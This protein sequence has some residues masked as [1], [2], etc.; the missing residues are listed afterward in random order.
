MIVSEDM[1]IDAVDD[2][3]V[4][5]SVIKRSEVLRTTPIFVSRT[6]SYSITATNSS[7]NNSRR[8]VSAIQADGDHRWR[9]TSL[10][11]KRIPRP[12][13]DDSFKNSV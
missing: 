5:K 8:L 11:G 7:F 13:G 9:G 12:R 4:P 2:Q 10:P 6:S 1:L 3:D